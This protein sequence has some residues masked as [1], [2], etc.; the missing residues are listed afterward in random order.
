MII[1]TG[2]WRRW[3]RNMRVCRGCVKSGCAETGCHCLEQDCIGDER[4]Y[5]WGC[6]DKQK[7]WE[8]LRE[9]G[10]SEL[11]YDI[12]S[13]FRAVN[14]I[15]FGDTTA[16][17]YKGM[18]R[19]IAEF[20]QSLLLDCEKEEMQYNSL[21]TRWTPGAADEGGDITDNSNDG[22]ESESVSGDSS[23]S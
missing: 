23:G 19:L 14:H 3:P 20:A 17:T 21:G 11:G 13:D 6:P 15:S 1:E 9:K 12:G 16:K 4:H 18:G 7:H 22:S 2:R 8:K 5:C 10:M